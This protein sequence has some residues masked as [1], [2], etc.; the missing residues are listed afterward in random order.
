M[1][2]FLIGRLGASLVSLFGASL[3]AFLILRLSPGDPARLFLGPFA[4]R[5]A[6]DALRVELGLDGSLASQY[7]L[8][9]ANFLRGDWGFSYSTGQ[10]VATLIARRFPATLELGLFAFLLAFVAAVALALVAAYRRGPTDAG[11]RAVSFFA[12]GVPPFWFGLVLLLVFFEALGW[13][14]GP[15]GRLSLRTI[16]PPAVTGFVTVDALLAG[17]GAAFRDALAHL[18]LPGVTLA[19]MPFSFLFRLLRANLIDIAREPFITVARSRGLTRWWAFVRHALPNAFLPTLT[20]SGLLF[21]QLLAGSVLV[22]RVFVWP[23]VG[24]L[25][26]DGV[27][28]QDFSVV[29]AFILLSAVIYVLCNLAVDLIAGLIDPR[30]AGAAR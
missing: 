15:D 19:L 16:P 24:A 1:S 20:A 12:M 11:A 29:Q 28:K 8:Y 27:L 25:V 23:G 17:D 18:I 22:E 6:V 9:I 26:T 3:V 13:L 14:P 7:L 5:E 2:R 30:V 21:G 10:P 4:G